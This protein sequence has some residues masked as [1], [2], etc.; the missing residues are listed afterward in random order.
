M[1]DFNRTPTTFRPQTLPAKQTNTVGGASSVLYLDGARRAP[2]SRLPA[3]VKQQVID[4]GAR[5][6]REYA[7]MMRRAQRLHASILES[8]SQ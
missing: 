4:D 2:Y 6:L 7:H 8:V 3:N 1:S 5:R